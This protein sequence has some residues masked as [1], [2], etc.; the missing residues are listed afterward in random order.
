M[1]CHYYNPDTGY[2]TLLPIRAASRQHYVFLVGDHHRWRQSI[3]VLVDQRV[4]SRA[5]QKS[6]ESN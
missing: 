5:G 1:L 3:G 4:Q 2:L 6:G